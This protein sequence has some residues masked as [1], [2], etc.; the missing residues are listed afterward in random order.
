MLSII[1]RCTHPPS[2]LS[3][4]C[5]SSGDCNI[6][7]L[8]RIESCDS[9]CDQL[10]TTVRQSNAVGHTICPAIN[11]MSCFTIMGY[12]TMLDTDGVTITTPIQLQLCEENN[13]NQTFIGYQSSGKFELSPI[14]RPECCLSQFLHPKSYEKIY[15]KYC[16]TARRDTTSN[17]IT[18]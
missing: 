5:S 1:I 6:G 7:D 10:F 13:S 17:W 8:I 3:S 9:Y 11:P 16:T 12:K 15:P 4:E 18:Y 14:D 2:N